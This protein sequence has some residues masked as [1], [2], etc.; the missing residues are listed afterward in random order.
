MRVTCHKCG[1]S[2]DDQFRLTYCPHDTFAA[3]DGSNNFRHHTESEV[4]PPSAGRA[5]IQLDPTARALAAQIV[6]K[7]RPTFEHYDNRA[8]IESHLQTSIGQACMLYAVEQMKGAG[9]VVSETRVEYRHPG[10]IWKHFATYEDD[11][12]KAFAA[13]MR[14]SMSYTDREFRVIAIIILASPEPGQIVDRKV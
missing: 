11:P 5:V 14:F 8:E 12:A 2:Y 6:S 4:I 9:V 3:N 13:A 7:L 1:S 10:G